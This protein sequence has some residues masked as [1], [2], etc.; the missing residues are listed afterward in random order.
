[1]KNTTK[2]E[3]IV[4]VCSINTVDELNDVI[5]NGTADEKIALI[6]HRGIGFD[7]FISYPNPAVRAAVAKQMY[8]FEV[9]S[10]DVAPSVREVVACTG[11]AKEVLAFDDA[12]NVRLGVFKYLR[13]AYKTKSEFVLFDKERKEIIRL[14]SINRMILTKLAHDTSFKVSFYSGIL[15]DKVI[16]DE[17]YQAYLVSDKY[18]LL[19]EVNRFVI[20][21]VV[22]GEDVKNAIYEGVISGRLHEL[23]IFQMS[24]EEKRI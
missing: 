13:E 17:L 2:L 11:Y 3:A 23:P 24:D 1:M 16:A 7:I 19:T 22:D 15:L 6:E 14:E 10:K 12:P 5:N 18:D 21:N 4:K 9:L 8:G 20:E